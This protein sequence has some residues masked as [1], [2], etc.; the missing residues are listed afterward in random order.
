MKKQHRL[1]REAQDDYWARRSRRARRALAFRRFLRVVLAIV[2]AAV[3]IVGATYAAHRAD[4]HL[5][6]PGYSST[7]Q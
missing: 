7:G 6:I 4:H 1:Y 2:I 5:T 3:I